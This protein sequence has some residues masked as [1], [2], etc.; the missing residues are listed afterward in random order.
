MRKEEPLLVMNLSLS[1][2]LFPSFVFFWSTRETRELFTTAT[3]RY[4]RLR[5]NEKLLQYV[6]SQQQQRKI[7]PPSA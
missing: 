7:V 5:H 3:L 4:Q 1:S 6:K 2:F